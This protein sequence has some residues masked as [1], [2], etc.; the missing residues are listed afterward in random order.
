MVQTI[1][2][3]VAP[4]LAIRLSPHYFGRMATQPSPP[5]RGAYQLS[6]DD[7]AVLLGVT[8]GKVRDLVRAGLAPCLIAKVPGTTGEWFDPATLDILRRALK[9]GGPMDERRANEVSDAVRAYVKAFPPLANYDAALEQKTPV[10]ARSRSDRVYAHVQSDVVAD[11]TRENHPE[12]PNAWFPHTV[13]SGL[14]QLGATQVRGIRGLGEG[15]QRWHTW[16]R[17][18]LSMW[19]ASPELESLLISGLSSREEDEPVSV[20]KDRQDSYLRDPLRTDG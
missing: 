18:P 7:V 11:F 2:P 8:P 9:G 16:W 1:S 15:P 20:S 10:L 14:K 19:S 3:P 13:A 5:E 6:I 17:L 12:L 4:K